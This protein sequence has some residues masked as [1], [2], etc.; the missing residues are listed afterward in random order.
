M[1]FNEAAKSYRFLEVCFVDVLIQYSWIRANLQSSESTVKS[2]NC[3]KSTGKAGHL[4]KL[5]NIETLFNLLWL[6][7][8]VSVDVNCVRV[9]PSNMLT[10]CNSAEHI[11]L[12]IPAKRVNHV[13]D[14]VDF[15]LV[16]KSQKHVPI[17]VNE[18]HLTFTWHIDLVKFHFDYI[19]W[20]FDLL[21]L[22]FSRGNVKKSYNLR[23][24]RVNNR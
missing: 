14:F 22:R 13:A 16:D 6:C 23:L 2:S 24:H 5:T 12:I 4:S 10:V 7:H 20:V 17:V 19:S 15:R 1:L 9:E 21:G 3:A 8:E 11:V 18:A